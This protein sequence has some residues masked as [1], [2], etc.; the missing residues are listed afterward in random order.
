V[1]TFEARGFPLYYEVHGA[2]HVRTPLVLSMGMG[3]SC[4]GWLPL[5][6]PEFSKSRPTVIYDHRGVGKSGDP[7]ED[8]RT[9]ELAEDLLALLD[10]LRIGHAHVLGGFLG[11]LAAQ[12]LAIAHPDRVRSL[13]L[14]GSFARADGRLRMLLDLWEGMVEHDIPLELQ[15]KNRLTWTL[16]DLAFE[17]EDL[18]EAIQR[19]YLREGRPL[20]D[21]AF[22]RQARAVLAHDT[23]SRLERV[24][25]PTLVVAGEQDILTPPH[26]QRELA[27]HIPGSRLVLVRGSGHLV[28][29]EHTARFNRMVTRFV[30]EY[31]EG[32]AAF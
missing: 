5:Q 16:H 22:V 1:P 29:V 24:Q 25:A 20:S 26:L 11:G 10:H 31:D 4:V 14:L 28:A 8:F 21:K 9:L 6:V 17:Q 19:F 27:A 32:D 23:L 18:I 12:E 7:E 2:E 13:I 3:G 30:E 15:I